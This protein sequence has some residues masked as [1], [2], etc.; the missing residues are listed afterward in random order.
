MKT[1][2]W[3]GTCAAVI[4]V[5]TA[6][7]M[8]QA[9]QTPQTPPQTP[10]APPTAPQSNQ[11][12]VTVTGCLRAA[13]SSTSSSAAATPETAKPDTDQKFVLTEATAAP[14]AAPAAAPTGE[15]STPQAPPAAAAA[16]TPSASTYRLIAN[17]S[18]LTPHV[19]KKLALTGTI[20]SA[21]AAAASQ[22]PAGNEAMMPSLKVESGKI[23]ADTCTAP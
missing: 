21:A 17:P 3:T 10:P 19:G 23:V 16:N 15:P 20:E 12:K 7:M 14:A 5:S 2:I 13:P 4:A 8:A 9:P 1:S 22:S 6:A 11:D 18:A